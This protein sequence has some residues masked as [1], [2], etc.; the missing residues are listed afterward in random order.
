[1]EIKQ[2][3]RTLS[4]A[5]GVSGYEHNLAATVQASCPWADEIKSDK[6]GNLIM[7]KKAPV[8]SRDQR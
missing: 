2:V 8:R 4:E 1:M 6:L 5:S 3:L 7:L